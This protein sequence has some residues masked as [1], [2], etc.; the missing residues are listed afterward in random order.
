MKH[1]KA[2]KVT[3][4]GES[5]EC[6]LEEQDQQTIDTQGIETEFVGESIQRNTVLGEHAEE[7]EKE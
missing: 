2:A 4:V 5:K 7:R 6:T 3:S 1:A